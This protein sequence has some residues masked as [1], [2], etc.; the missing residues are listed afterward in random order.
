VEQ[1]A[2][3]A[4]VPVLLGFAPFE[5]AAEDVEVGF[6]WW[7]DEVVALWRASDADGVVFLE[8]DAGLAVESEEHG[9]RGASEFDFDEG[10]VADDDGTVGESVRADGRD[11]ERFD[12]GMNDGA[13]SREGVGGGTGGRGDDEAVGAIADDEIVVD[14]EFEFDHACKSGFVDDGVVEDVLRVN[15]LICTKEL[16]LEHGANGFGGAAGE[17]FFEGG[18]EF[19]DGEA[20]EKAEAAHVDGENGKAARSGEAS[21]GEQRAVTAEDEEEIGLSSD[22]FAGE[23]VRGAG[24]SAGGFL[25]VE[26]AKMAGFEPAEERGDDDGE[27]GAARARD[28]ADGLDG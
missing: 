3:Q 12:G 5:F 13:A 9:F 6:F 21:G 24:E 20:G 11:D 16:D 15:D 2:A 18:I 19:V 17:S 25:V 4:G 7:L 8:G 27:V 26:D 28:D 14:G 1:Y 22:L 23:R 10:G